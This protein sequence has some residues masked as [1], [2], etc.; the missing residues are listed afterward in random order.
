MYEV[1][2]I[3]FLFYYFLGVELLRRKM[4]ESTMAFKCANLKII[5][6]LLQYLCLNNL[7]QIYI[8]CLDQ[9]IG[10]N[11]MQRQSSAR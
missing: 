7:L 2:E 8:A 11:P 10:V 9:G 5:H 6:L 1:I 4:D 3:I